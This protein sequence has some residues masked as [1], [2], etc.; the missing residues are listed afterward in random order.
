RAPDFGAAFAAKLH[1]FDRPLA[2]FRELQAALGIDLSNKAFDFNP[3]ALLTGL[4]TSVTPVALQFVLQVV[5]FFATLFFL[6]LGR[7][8]FRRHA[9]NWFSTRD[10]RLRALKILNDIEDNLGGYLIVVTAINLGLGIVTTVAALLLGLPSP[11]LWGALA[12]ALNYIP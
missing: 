10:G 6:I 7:A 4:V 5:L 9:V 1:L 12:F 8:G 3:A 2:S 11:L